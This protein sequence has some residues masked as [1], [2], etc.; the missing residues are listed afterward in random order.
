MMNPNREEV[1]FALALEKPAETRSAFRDAL[2]AGIETD[3]KTSPFSIPLTEV[4]VERTGEG[5]PVT[6]R[7]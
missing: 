2:V 3:L 6:P 4:L 1:L 5:S 7:E